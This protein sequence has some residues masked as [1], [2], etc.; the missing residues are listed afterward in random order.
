MAL[1]IRWLERPSLEASAEVQTIELARRVISG[2]LRYSQG[3]R[4]SMLVDLERVGL[5][6]AFYPRS[7]LSSRRAEARK[8]GLAASEMNSPGLEV[9]LSE[10][11]SPYEAAVGLAAGPRPGPIPTEAEADPAW[12]QSEFPF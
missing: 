11:L 8:V 7:V 10:L 5:D 12:E 9:D 3:E 2:E 1:E 4:L 6:Q